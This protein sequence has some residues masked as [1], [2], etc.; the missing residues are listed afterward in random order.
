M[1][2]RGNPRKIY[3]DRTPYKDGKRPFQKDFASLC[4]V[5]IQQFDAE[6]ISVENARY[7]MV[8]K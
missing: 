5:D 6:N 7:V 2:V 3:L 8:I 4:F 1:V